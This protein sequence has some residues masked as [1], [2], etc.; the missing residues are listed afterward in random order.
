MIKKRAMKRSKQLEKAR[1]SQTVNEIVE[2]SLSEGT[3]AYR[4]DANWSEAEAV[5]KLGSNAGVQF[6]AGHDEAVG[7][8]TMVVQ[9][10]EGGGC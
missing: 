9:A 6:E 7:K 2:N 10:G 8:M 1:I 4:N 3:I 5:W